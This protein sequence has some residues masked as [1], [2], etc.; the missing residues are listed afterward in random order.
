[1]LLPLPRTPCQLPA[2]SFAGHTRLPN[3]TPNAP[4]CLLWTPPPTRTSHACLGS[5]P[6]LPPCLP[7]AHV[8]RSAN[9]TNLYRFS[10]ESKDQEVG[11]PVASCLLVRAPIGSEKPDGSRA[12]VIR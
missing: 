4:A 9:P 7:N 6:A 12:W 11:L 5:P 2:K 10:L 8:P 1:M 3:S